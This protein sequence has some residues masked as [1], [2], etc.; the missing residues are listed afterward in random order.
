[1][2]SNVDARALHRAAELLGGTTHLR[3]YLHVPTAD[4]LRWMDGSAA[5]PDSVFLKAVELVVRSS[6]SGPTTS[7]ESREEQ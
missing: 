4:L 2:A 6:A 5:A 7:T 1:M 3:D